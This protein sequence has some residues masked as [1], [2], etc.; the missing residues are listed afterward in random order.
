MMVV[1][2][3]LCSSLSCGRTTCL[4][5]RRLAEVELFPLVFVYIRVYYCIGSNVMGGWVGGQVWLDFLKGNVHIFYVILIPIVIFWLFISFF[6]SIFWLDV[7]KNIFM[8]TQVCKYDSNIGDQ[9]V[10]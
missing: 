3:V 7:N 6:S 10:H 1:S 8:L 2:S 9:N 4:M 5:P